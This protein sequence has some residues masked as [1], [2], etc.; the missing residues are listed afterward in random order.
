M[1]LLISI[2]AFI[3]AVSVIVS[4]HEFGH[5]WVARRLG[6]K[7]LRFSIGFGKPLW[8]KV[9]K[10]GTEYVV[11]PIPIGGYVKMLDE[12]EG[13]VDPHELHCAFNRKSLGARTAIVAAGPLFNFI[14]AIVLYY[15]M[16][17]IGVI[18]MK[19]VVGE[20][21]SGSIAEEAGMVAGDEFLEISGTKVESWQQALLALL[22]AGFKEAPFQVAVADPDGIT[23]NI[24]LDAV[25]INPLEDDDF[26][27]QL[28]IQPKRWQPD[29]VVGAVLSNT[30]AARAQLREGDRI[31]SFAG[32]AVEDWTALVSLAQAHPGQIVPVSVI[33]N[34]VTFTLDLEVGTLE[35]DGE[36][37]GYL[38]VRSRGPTPQEQKQLQALVRYGPLE[39]LWLALDKT[40]SVT[41]LTFKVI[42]RLLL[43]E[44]SL[45]NISGPVGI[46][47]YAGISLLL[48]WGAF[49]GLLALLSIS[50]GI[51]NLLPVPML[52]GGHLLYY[53]IE[54]IK[55]SPLSVQSQAVGQ[56]IGIFMLGCLMFLALYNDFNRLLG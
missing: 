8:R 21:V 54:F 38:G 22:D 18:G 26:L 39:S 50:I 36:V 9:G 7:V 47:E 4:F 34:D 2:L 53:L 35:R 6:V 56:W 24:V 16:F 14:L 10:G 44:A 20:V 33:R 52:D 46:A 13:E 19:P 1:I 51:L 29:T 55:G 17:T 25:G 42:K 31:V 37:V 48:G 40:W 12:R 30:G 11:A 23:R 45:N 28:G 41:A 15:F 49:L 3:I 27:G 43:G 5:F 32:Q